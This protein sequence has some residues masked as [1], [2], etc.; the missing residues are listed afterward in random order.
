MAV[1]GEEKLVRPH[2][3]QCLNGTLDAD[4]LF[5]VCLQDKN[6][7][8]AASFELEDDEET[9]AMWNFK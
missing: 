8:V 4:S 7:N 6:G 1:C 9:R 5:S 3:F 2:C